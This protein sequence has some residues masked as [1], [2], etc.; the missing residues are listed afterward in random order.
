MRNFLNH[1]HH[2]NWFLLLIFFV[3]F[4]NIYANARQEAV[5][6][7]YLK[8]WIQE[9]LETKIG[10]AKAIKAFCVGKKKFMT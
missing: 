1:L 3:G 9:K 6:R 2:E 10:F 4:C 5:G 8:I 7:P